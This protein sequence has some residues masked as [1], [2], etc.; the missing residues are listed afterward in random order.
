MAKR[1]N[2]DNLQE[3]FW[4]LIR[5]TNSIISHLK[6]EGK[7][8]KKESP[9]DWTKRM[10]FYGKKKKLLGSALDWARELSQKTISQ[11]KVRDKLDELAG[12]DTSLMKGEAL[13]PIKGGF[14][15]KKLNKEMV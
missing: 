13:G 10:T 1:M 2:I 15:K 8:L 4:S 11:E 12:E 5:E 9:K 14:D 3:R 6:G 7:W